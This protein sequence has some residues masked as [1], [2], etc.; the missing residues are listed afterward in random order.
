MAF[1]YNI[2][3]AGVGQY[4]FSVDSVRNE[5][6]HHPDIGTKAVMSDEC[7]MRVEDTDMT[8]EHAHDVKLE[9]II[10]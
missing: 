4:G 1:A 6:L 7:N 8:C 9:D 5:S 2:E 10:L 3:G